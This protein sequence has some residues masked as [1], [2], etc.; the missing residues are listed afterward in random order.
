METTPEKLALLSNEDKESLLLQVR[1]ELARKF[2]AL[3]KTGKRE[4]QKYILEWGKVLFPDKFPLPFC[5]EMHDYF[6]EIR[7]HPFTNTEAPRGHAK[8]TIKCFLIPIFQALE[9]PLLYR[10]YLN[11]QAT[12]EKALS[13][14]TSIMAE[15]ET[16]N[17][18]RYMYGN[19]V[20]R[21]RW[22]GQQFC[23]S[24]GVVFSAAGA[25]QSIRGINYRQLRP[26]YIIVDDLYDDE[27]IH[28]TDSTIKK[29]GWFWGTLYPARA[30]GRRASIHIQGTAI[31]TEDLMESLKKSRRAKSRT[32]RAI[33][34]MDK[35]TVLWPEL[36][37]Y[38]SLMSDREDMGSL[39]F[40]REYQNDRLDDSTSKIKRSWLTNWEQDPDALT[41]DRFRILLTVILGNDPSIGKKVE[42]DFAAFCVVIKWRQHDSAKANF[43]ID[44]I[45]QGQLSLDERVKKLLNISSNYGGMRRIRQVRIESISGFQDYTAEVKR[46]TTLPVKEITWVKDKVAVL[47]NKSK[48]FEFGQVRINKNLPQGI[49]D[50]LV[51]QLT[52]NHP[53]HDDLRDAL[54]LCLEEA[55]SWKD[56]V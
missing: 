23:L 40:F 17:L 4:N 56:W 37:T 5:A 49:K 29:N 6:C 21:A 51:H 55:K 27:D 31:N 36:N 28:N 54:F 47:E 43:F 39:I 11:V 9:Q 8:S 3:V 44:H 13:I 38:D 48:H 33:T 25:G 32:F 15:I 42:N 46:R 2:A 35:K 10:H 14:N 19:L 26:D 24:S 53:K 34:D 12:E 50:A 20:S 1:A 16:N 22:T 7:N 45:E 30:K 18:L 52:T 41:F